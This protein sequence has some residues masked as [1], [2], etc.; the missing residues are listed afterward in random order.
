MFIMRMILSIIILLVNCRAISAQTTV[1]ADH[2][3]EGC[4]I[5]FEKVKSKIE[6]LR[7]KYEF[8]VQEY[9][10]GLFCSECGRTKSE[11][12]ERAHLNFEQHIRDGATRNRHALVA[13][14]QLYDN[15]YGEYLIDFND[16]KKEYDDRYNDCGGDNSSAVLQTITDQQFELYKTELETATQTYNTQPMML[17]VDYYFYYAWVIR[18]SIARWQT[19]KIETTLFEKHSYSKSGNTGNS[20]SQAGKL[21]DNYTR[22]LADKQRII[23]LNSRASPLWL[24]GDV[25]AIKQGE[26]S[27]F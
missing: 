22:T 26:K 13:S 11:I 10:D 25:F 4:K 3:D 19:V 8:N 27:A 9:K 18:I 5:K 14:R 23:F 21:F 24:S 7:K 12:E 2:N 6:A 16:L 1:L 15:L 17:S 20:I